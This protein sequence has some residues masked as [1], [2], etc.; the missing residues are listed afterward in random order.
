M[1]KRQGGITFGDLNDPASR[2]AKLAKLDRQYKL[3]PDLG[4]QPR[5]SFLA[6]I[7]NLNPEM[8]G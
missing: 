5:T 3:L 4:V 7:R 2:V 6:K 1:Y 8:Q